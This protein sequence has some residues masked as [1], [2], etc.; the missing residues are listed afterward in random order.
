MKWTEKELEIVSNEINSS[1]DYLSSKLNRTKNSIKNKL[2]RL[3]SKVNAKTTDE[4][5]SKKSNFNYRVNDFTNEINEYSSYVLG[6]I[7][8]DGYLLKNR[9]STAITLVKDDMVD[10]QWIFEKTGNWYASDRKRTGKRESRTLT[11]YNPILLNR[12]IELDFDKKSYLSPIKL[13]Q[14]IPE[15]Y[16][17]YLIRGI[18]DGDGCFYHNKKGQSCQLT[19]ASTFQQD[20]TLYLEFFSKLG[21]DFKIQKRVNKKNGNSSSIIRL[22]QRDKINKFCAWMYEGYEKDNIGFKR[23]YTKSLNFLKKQKI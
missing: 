9:K 2:R 8:S 18:I 14:L 7:W 20:W 10:I 17:K 21:F 5:K 4:L 15:N 22:C 16:K 13:F 11:A 23:K 6:L 3:N 19:I 12:F 1:I